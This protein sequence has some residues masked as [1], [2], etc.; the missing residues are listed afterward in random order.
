MFFIHY[1]LDSPDGILTTKIMLGAY[2][3]ESLS[4]SRR[5]AFHDLRLAID[6]ADDQVNPDLCPEK[7]WPPAIYKAVFDALG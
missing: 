6:S 7:D 5:E 4:F 3:F 1:F 2:C